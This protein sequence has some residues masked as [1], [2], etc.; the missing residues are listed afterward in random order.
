V[1]IAFCITAYILFLYIVIYSNSYI[2]LQIKS[3]NVAN[4]NNAFKSIVIEKKI[5]YDTIKLKG[6]KY[7]V[8]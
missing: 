7:V 8:R 5:V 1:T 4:R 3:R 6:K 2:V